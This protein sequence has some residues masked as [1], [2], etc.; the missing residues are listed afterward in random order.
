[1]EVEE[2]KKKGQDWYRNDT[3]V[4]QQHTYV[5]SIPTLI[6]PYTNDKLIWT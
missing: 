3:T 2:S 1:M 6:S 5:D 4:E